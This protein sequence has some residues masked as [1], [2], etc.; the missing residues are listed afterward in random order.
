MLTVEIIFVAT[1][2]VNAFYDKSFSEQGQTGETAIPGGDVLPEAGP[3][4]HA[5]CL[6]HC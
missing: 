6:G 2:A 5:F 1:A 3:L 4:S